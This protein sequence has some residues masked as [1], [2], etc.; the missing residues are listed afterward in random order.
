MSKFK[1]N[2]KSALITPVML[3]W[4]LAGPITYILN[5]VHTWHGHAPIW[6][7]LLINLTLDAF[8]AAI[9]PITWALWFVWRAMGRSTPLELI[10]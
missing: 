2:L 3:T 7:K 9:W 1:E 8:L 5:V 10:L 4:I 6:L